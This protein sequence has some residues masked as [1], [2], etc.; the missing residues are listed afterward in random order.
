MQ[1]GSHLSTRRLEEG[2][3]GTG[4][5]EDGERHPQQKEP[6][7]SGSEGGKA[8]LKELRA[9]DSL[10]PGEPHSVPGTPEQRAERQAWA[11]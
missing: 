4:V 6:N 1:Q 3:E 10:A 7:D 11:H 9:E 8:V 2:K 5:K